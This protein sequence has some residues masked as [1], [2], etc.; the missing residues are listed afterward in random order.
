MTD[1]ENS[2][3]SET[4][5]N[6]AKWD[7][8]KNNPNAHWVKTRDL[9]GTTFT[10]VKA[11]AGKVKGRASIIFECADGALFSASEGGTIGQQ[12]AR[13]GLPPAGKYTI[14]QSES[15]ASP[16]GYALSLRGV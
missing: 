9:V 12:V 3:A 11:K 1:T 13:S 2:P 14:V 6:A 4:P 8:P 7:A 5:T 10:V 15:A 16:T